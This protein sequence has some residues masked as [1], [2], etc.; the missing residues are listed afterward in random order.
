MQRSLSNDSG[1]RFGYITLL[2]RPNVGKSTLLNRIVG[3]KI[4]IT[5]HR[6]QTT[7]HRILGIRTTTESQ[8]VVVDTPGIQTKRD[9]AINRVTNRTAVTS[10][11]NVDVIVMIIDCLGWQSEDGNVLK[12]LAGRPTPVLLA[13]NKIDV[14]REKEALLPLMDKARRLYEFDEIVPISAKSGM[15]VDRLIESVEN[16]LMFGSAGF[17]VEQITDRSERFICSEFI[18][19]QLFR[20]LGQELPYATA[21]EL[22]NFEDDKNVIRITNQIWVERPSHKAIVIGKEGRRLKQIGMRARLEM[23]RFLGKKVHLELRVKVRR[24]WTDS[25]AAL[26]ALGYNEDLH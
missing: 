14:L 3:K 1:F 20:Q 6:P 23:Q 12:A 17:P 19:E 11:E 10:T 25:A 18:R 22:M 7:R 9:R 4:S 13:I 26:D 2:G 15:N 5:S 16:R 8:I 24:G 21:V